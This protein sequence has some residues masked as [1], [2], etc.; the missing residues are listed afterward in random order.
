MRRGGP[1]GGL[2]L[3]INVLSKLASVSLPAGKHADG[4][5]LWLV[6][7][8]KAAGKWVLRLTIHGRRREMG[9]GRWPDVAISEAR[10]RADEARRLCRDGKD[11]LFERW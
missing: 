6:K 10:S 7:R 8:S 11:P 3:Y 1:E 2:N 9:L 4:Q 5:G